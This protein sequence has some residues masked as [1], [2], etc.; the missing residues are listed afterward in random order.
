M[1]ARDDDTDGRDRRLDEAVTEFLQAA[2]VG[3]A[4]SPDEWIAR[5]PDLAPELTAF[6]AAHAELE[7]LTAF[8]R[9]AR[10]ARVARPAD[11]TI[12]AASNGPP[13]ARPAATVRT[14]GDY[15]L[16]EEVARGGMGVVFRARQ[17]SLNRTVA[18]K[19]ILAG[20]LASDADVRRF[21]SEAEA[22]ANLD[23]PNIVP[24]Y[25][26]GEHEGQRYFSMKLIEGSDLAG[27][28]RGAW[29]GGQAGGAA[30]QRDVAGLLARIARAVHHAHRFG[31][32]HR[33]LKPAN[34]LLSFDGASHSSPSPLAGAGV[35]SRP[36]GL[37]GVTPHVTDFGLAK[38][39]AG[40]GDV[41][42]TG[43]VVGTPSYMAPEQAAGKRG[44]STAAD[45]YSLGA[46]LYE[47][48]TGRPPF[49]EENPLD[50]VLQ[51]LQREPVR[52]RTLNPRLDRDLETVCL[53]CL[54][55]DP[56]RRYGSAEALAEDLE[57][58]RAGEPIRARRSGMAER[59]LKWA[60]RR[61]AAAALI[62]VVA[63][64][65]L[66]VLAVGAWYNYRLT[67]TLADLQ[68]ANDELAER[69]LL[70]RRQLYDYDV[71]AVQDAWAAGKTARVHELLH[72]LRPAAGQKDVRGFEWSYYWSLCREGVLTLATGASRR[73][74]YSPDGKTLATAGV[75]DTGNGTIVRLWDAATGQALH[76]WTG[77]SEPV[78]HLA[79][80]P[81]G[82][83][84]AAAA[85]DTVIWY[86]PAARARRGTHHVQGWVVGLAF[87]KADPESVVIA[88]RQNVRPGERETGSVERL[89][90]PTRA[91]RSVAV[92]PGEALLTIALSPDGKTVAIGTDQ[93]IGLWDVATGQR[94]IDL[95]APGTHTLAFSPDGETLAAY[96]VGFLALIGAADGKQRAA[97][98]VRSVWAANSLTYS[99][100]GKTLV[101]A[102]DTTVQLWDVASQQ[103]KLVL[104]GPALTVTGLAFSPDGTRLAAASD[105]G[106]PN[107]PRAANVEQ[108]VRAPGE[109][110]VWDL[111]APPGPESVPL[112]NFAVRSLAFTGDG[113]ALTINASRVGRQH[114]EVPETIDGEVWFESVPLQT[115]RTAARLQA[116]D[117]ALPPFAVDG[118]GINLRRAAY[119]ADGSVV[120]AA[121]DR[122]TKVVRLW[123][124]AAGRLLREL[125][126][127]TDPY[128]VAFSPDGR[129]MAT[130]G[131]DRRVTLWNTDRWTERAVLRGHATWI[132][133]LAFSDDGTTLA[134]SGP[135]GT[136]KLWDVAAGR[137]RAALPRHPRRLD[138]LAFAP[139]GR[140][141][142][143]AW[144]A[145]G[146]QST[147]TLWDGGT[148]R[149]LG[150]VDG[151]MP[152]GRAV[153]S[154]DG[155]WLATT[156][157]DG[158]ARRHGVTLCATAS[159]AVSATWLAH[160]SWI[161]ALAF[162]PD[163]AALATASADKTVRVWDVKTP[164]RRAERRV[165]RRAE[166]PLTDGAQWVAFTRDGST[167][168]AAAR[169]N[170]VRL[171]D[172][173]NYTERAT[174]RAG[175]GSDVLR[176]TLSPGG[177][178][179]AAAGINGPLVQLWD[180]ATGK[181]CGRLVVESGSL[182]EPLF[183]PGGR[184]LLT[185]GY[186]SL[187]LWD[188]G[189]GA[190]RAVLT[191]P[192]E[193]RHVVLVLAMTDDGKAVLTIGHDR[194]TAT[195]WDVTT[196]RPRAV[197]GGFAAPIGTAA[198][199][200]GGT[201][202]ATGHENGT[203]E[204]W[205]AATGRK[206]QT[207][208]GHR[209]AIEAL[210]FTPDGTVL[211]SGGWDSTVRLWNVATGAAL[212]ALQGKEHGVLALAL[213]DDGALA[214]VESTGGVRL[215][216]WRTGRQRAV[217]RLDLD[218]QTPRV[219]ALALAPDGRT[220]ATAVGH[221][222]KL[223]DPV[224][225]LERLTLWEHA[226]DVVA[227]A[228]APDGK[229]L[230]AAS[231]RELRLWHA[232]APGE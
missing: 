110:R 49:R 133:G 202:L 42:R 179:L 32:L 65:L 117:A 219:R 154:P 178:T 19:M 56:V 215:W 138:T 17:V 6:F 140:T 147:V 129:T 3:R 122:A 97:P 31:I 223:W 83:V 91:A 189:R 160:D 120:A 44:L 108:A 141:L 128:A 107:P 159:G 98:K 175:H 2:E 41:T 206:R 33:D 132:D 193:S 137:E 43:A 222:L 36:P 130:L 64:A 75:A 47:L 24:I 1:A 13:G 203:V 71:R 85:H 161:A 80:S 186:Q 114:R 181:E 166:C 155:Q 104:Q 162:A 127:D 106:P 164:A 126:R 134:T 210:A 183:A 156:Y 121:G 89:R 176:F 211:A 207:L 8:H 118:N 124:A 76:T 88:V 184:T 180:V 150:H 158:A 12:D 39:V 217:L 70:V 23:H 226:D 191:P 40:D 173:D 103:E 15:E 123:D 94:R 96:R 63:A 73:I 101:A 165:E 231:H 116:A 86:D 100:D 139:G 68:Q 82:K 204:L 27:V 199:A 230:A 143:T 213:A 67:N 14:F 62:G 171:W 170:V 72:A 35:R 172:T 149:E 29:V 5:H 209:A 92:L 38:R 57:R 196:R 34:I 7:R 87:A 195:L 228:F 113:R 157:Y 168:I 61:P 136:V 201:Q 26:V 60:R 69:E 55:K 174:L 102:L 151:A 78:N 11:A 205:D 37:G 111:T 20:P 10:V 169:D 225:G 22:A 146:G 115:R 135:D 59:S 152:G 52:P 216:D 142:V 51:V 30:W 167:L 112:Q 105:G 192:A 84:L 125:T 48:L 190:E 93:R 200:P 218:P 185:D 81:D 153:F 145:A 21:L 9:V 16:L 163:G 90:L 198:F 220:L 50:T 99:P 54:E 25:E 214:A 148:G 188:T 221:T 45:V 66:A 119:S 79:F 77:L 131:V 229:T 109:I 144:S 53:K 18:L 46:I 58:W 28:V 187:R 232:D 74:A 212:A 224:T 4:P 208:T 95:G 182:A 177:E 227:V 194:T 197:L